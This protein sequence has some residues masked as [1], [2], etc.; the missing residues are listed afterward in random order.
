MIKAHYYSHTEEAS[1]SG[2]YEICFDNRMSTW[3]EKT[4]WFEVVIHDPEDD[5][6]DDYIGNNDTYANY[7]IKLFNLMVLTDSEEWN[8]IK[9]R[10]EDYESLYEM[11]SSD[12]HNFIHSIR[13]KLGQ[14][15]HFQLMQGADMSRVS[16]FK[17]NFSNIS[18]N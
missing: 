17:I 15:K 11:S 3:A 16:S 4:V 8:D 2:D 14:V 10:N 6:Y 5:Y 13:L 12:L 18:V 9:G 7:L 1:V